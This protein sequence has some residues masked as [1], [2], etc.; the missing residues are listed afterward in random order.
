MSYK[1]KS[2][3]YFICFVIASATYYLSD[4]N[5][6]PDVKPLVAEVQMT[7]APGIDIIE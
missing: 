5:A 4:I 6:N 3:I 1:I 7:Q 2:L